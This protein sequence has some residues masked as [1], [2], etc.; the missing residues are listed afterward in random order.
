MHDKVKQFLD[1]LSSKI[2][3]I[4]CLSS[5]VDV[6][7]RGEHLCLGEG[8]LGSLS[9]RNNSSNCVFCFQRSSKFSSILVVPAGKA[10]ILLYQ[11]LDLKFKRHATNFLINFCSELFVSEA[12]FSSLYSYVISFILSDLML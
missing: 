12:S 9:V 10:S 4:V 8:E 3:V 1:Q 6:F 7:L 11:S 2:L 5:Q